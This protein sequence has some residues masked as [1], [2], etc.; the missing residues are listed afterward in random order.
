MQNVERWIN[1]LIQ[2]D[3]LWKFYKS[4]SWKDLKNKILEE[5]HN[6]CCLCKKVGVIKRYDIDAA[7]Q[8]HLIKTVH[9]INHVREHP[10]LALSRYYYDKGQER[11]NLI[12]VCKACH[13]KLHPEKLKGCT[14][15]E[16]K[17]DKYT[18]EERW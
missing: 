15:R 10:E 6:E 12:V 2:K 11:E 18:N 5:N 4:K 7:G 3:E 8:K 14:Q 13:N 17:R 9:H 1:E 16:K